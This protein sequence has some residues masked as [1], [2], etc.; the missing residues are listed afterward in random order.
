MNSRRQLIVNADDLGLSREVNAGIFA[1]H[2]E[3]IVSSASLMVR[4][5]ST[6][7]QAVEQSQSCPRL[8]L[9]LHVDLGEW[10]CRDGRWVTLYQVADLNDAPRV[11]RAIYQQL[12]IFRQMTGKDPT[13]LDSHQHVNRKAPTRRIMRELAHELH[14]PLR[15]FA[16]VQHCGA[17]Y[18]QTASGDPLHSA[19]SVESLLN[20]I[21]TLPAGI[22]ELACHP[23]LGD[24]PNTMYR[25]E[26]RLELDALCDPRLRAHLDAHDIQLISYHDVCLDA[27]AP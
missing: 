14:I 18:G 27:V 21:G 8:S 25:A 26:R 22:T 17:F 23:S 16:P 6:A 24:V 15:H 2:E 5:N 19:I 9:G 1:A 10:A 13:H 20:I 7:W 3:G 4:H 12:D 11:R